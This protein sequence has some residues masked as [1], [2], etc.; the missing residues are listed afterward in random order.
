MIKNIDGED[1]NLLLS[2]F[3]QSEDMNLSTTETL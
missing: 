1:H 3:Q 2:S